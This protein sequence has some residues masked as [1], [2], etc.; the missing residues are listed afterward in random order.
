MVDVIELVCG[1]KYSFE[2][3][4]KPALISFCVNVREN[5]PAG[6]IYAFFLKRLGVIP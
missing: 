2:S 5:T 4:V 3:T 6:G 1:V